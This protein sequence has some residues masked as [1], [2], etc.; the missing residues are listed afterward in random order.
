MTE[1]DAR[2]MDR[3]LELAARGL[4]NTWPNP[5]VGCVLV[6]GDEVVGEGWTQP[7]G[8]PHAEVHALAD[9]GPRARGA[10]A[11]V[12]L[13]PCAHHGRTGPCAVAL[14]EAG[15]ARVVVALGDPD[16][17]VSGRGLKI[18][19]DAGITVETEGSRV[20]PPMEADA[21]PVPCTPPSDAGRGPPPTV[22]RAVST[23]SGFPQ[24]TASGTNSLRGILGAEAPLSAI[25]SSI[26]VRVTWL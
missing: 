19:R 9:A 7:G 10:T 22:L 24:K 4:G 21:R 2:H 25:V 20:V 16:T 18:L 17:R 23:L 1:A 14:A 11:Y 13:E 26:E 3:A 6:H 5:S 8:R 12:T 15:I